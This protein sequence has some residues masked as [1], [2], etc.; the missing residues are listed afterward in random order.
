MR[1]ATSFVLAL[2]AACA[3][4]LPQVEGSEGFES[5]LPAAHLET[6]TAQGEVIGVDRSSPDRDLAEGLVLRV[7]G[8]GKKPFIVQ[9]APGWYLD[10]N[11]IGYGPRERL[12]VRGRRAVLEGEPVFVADEVR[13]GERRLLLRDAEGRPLWSREPRAR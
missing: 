4:T 6:T 8:D 2:T 1:F 5:A 9:L 7:Q 13:Q 11:G 10:E 12:E 3:P